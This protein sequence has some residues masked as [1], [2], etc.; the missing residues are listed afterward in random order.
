MYRVMCN[1]GEQW[2]GTL[3]VTRYT[4]HMIWHHPFMHSLGLP[5]AVCRIDAKS[6]LLLGAR[7]VRS[8]NCDAR[9]QATAP[10]L[11]IV[12]GISLPP[13]QFGGPWIDRL[14]TNSL[15]REVHPYFDEIAGMKVSSHLLIRRDGEY[16]QYVP[17]H[18]RAWHAGASNYRGRGACNDFSIGIELEG[19]D[20]CAYEP[21]QYRRLTDAILGLSSA[22]PSL[23][24]ERV[25]GHCDVAPGRKSDPGVAFDWP[26]LRAMLRASPPIR[27]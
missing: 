7:Q 25:V 10:E 5:S 23:S 8:A 20:E 3:H 26:R 11:I 15:P 9:P 21:V 1:V 16:V 13:G 19:T 4:S 22:Y 17:F 18:L 2:A 27:R 12:H 14:F 24:V 6:G